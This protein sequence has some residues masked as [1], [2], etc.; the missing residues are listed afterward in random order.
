MNPRALTRT[1]LLVALVAS[2]SAG[3]E[4]PTP[5]QVLA[6]TDVKNV[7][8]DDLQPFPAQSRSGACAYRG[9]GGK[10]VTLTLSEDSSASGSMM[11]TRRQMAGDKASPAPGPGTNAYRI[12]L[13]TANAIVFGKGRYVA[14]IELGPPSASDSGT[15]DRLARLAYDRLP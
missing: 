7:V 3:A 12:S 8:G 1:F 11:A 2:P 9:S 13:P 10:L 14:Q 15:L 5:C 4:D 6:E